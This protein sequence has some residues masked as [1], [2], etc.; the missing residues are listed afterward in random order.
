MHNPKDPAAFEAYVLRKQQAKK[1]QEEEDATKLKKSKDEE[2]VKKGYVPIEQWDKDR[3]KDD[4]GWEE[5]VQ[6]DG[7]RFGNKFQQNE[8]LRKNLK[9]W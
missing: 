6:F 7:Q 5:K 2:L 1:K 9:S 4:L 8:I 3:M